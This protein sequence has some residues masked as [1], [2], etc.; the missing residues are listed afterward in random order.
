LP[1]GMADL[2]ERK[3]RTTNVENNLQSIQAIVRERI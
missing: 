2:F 3:E 1:S